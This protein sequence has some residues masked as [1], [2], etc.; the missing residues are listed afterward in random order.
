MHNILIFT[1][2]HKIISTDIVYSNYICYIRQREIKYILHIPII[3]FP[4]Y[5]KYK[6]F[7]EKENLFILI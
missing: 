7:A 2:E 6:L 5:R 3:V 4:I 1:E